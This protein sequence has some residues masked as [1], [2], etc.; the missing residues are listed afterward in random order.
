MQNNEKTKIKKER[1]INVL[2]LS[3]KLKNYRGE[4]AGAVVCGVG[5]QLSLV[6]VS[7]IGAW[8][9]GLAIDGTLLEKLPLALGLLAGA[10]AARIL[11]YFL[12]MWLSHD[13]AFKVL[14]DFRILLFQA[15]ERVSPAI[16]LNMRSGQLVS[17]LMGDVELLEWFFAHSFGS[18]LVAVI[19]PVILMICMGLVSPVF[20]L[21][22]LIFL[23]II[24][25]IPLAMR[26]KADYQGKLVRGQL[27]EA[28]AVTM[29][30]IQGMKEI[31]SLNFRGR[32]WKKNEKYMD[33]LYQSQWIYGK[34]LGTEGAV[35]QAAL[36]CSMLCVTVAAARFVAQGR[37]DAALYPVLV[38]LAGMTLGPVVEICSTARNFGLIFAAADR[39][40]QVLEAKPQVEDTG[41]DIDTRCLE[42][43]IRFKQVCF[44]YGKDLDLAVENVSFTVFP[45]ETVALVGQS[46]AGKS[47]CI[48][49]L[50]RYWDPEAGEITIGGKD[51]KSISLKSLYDLTSVVLQDVYLFRE[52]IRENIRLGRQD[53]TDE[54][55]EQAAKMALA[56][57][58][59]MDLPKGYDTVAGEGGAKLSG[60]QRQRI[61]IA[62]AFLKNSPV[63]IMDEAVSNLDTENEKEIQ[64]SIQNSSRNRTTFLVAHRLSTIRSA[65]KIV[66]L[67]RGKVVQVGT[68][69]DLI[70]EE[71][72]F[73]DLIAAYIK[74]QSTGRR[75]RK[76]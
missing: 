21:L 74:T 30:G 70:K 13:V 48:Q 38:V 6:G 34:R 40:Y 29:E 73:K 56:H 71:G 49:L 60:G 24:V 19:V 3:A 57:G 16:L 23:C 9:V 46:G 64:Q 61:A 17:T 36:G 28:N 55:V 31:L 37:L 18:V 33:R 39:V 66:V 69:S 50:L 27:G 14:A 42:P 72:C 52:S 58:F 10:A 32:Y 11:F 8:I 1:L 15:I 63:L 54:E 47:T 22:M 26:K 12:E 51:I 41:R 25:Y 43:E 20:P 2:R 76:C 75:E 68:Y 5:H 45:G 62:R 59:I 4:M 7:V 44:R 35:L 53:A 65:D 67:Q